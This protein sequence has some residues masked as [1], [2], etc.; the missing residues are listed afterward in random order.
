VKSGLKKNLKRNTPPHR[1]EARTVVKGREIANAKRG[2]LGPD[3]QL[4]GGAG[5]GPQ[6]G[7]TLEKGPGKGRKFLWTCQVLGGGVWGTVMASIRKR[8][9]KIH[10]YK[11]VG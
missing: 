10:K 5:G 6:K 9:R 2:D 8:K 3:A 11:R 4:A 7:S 1:W